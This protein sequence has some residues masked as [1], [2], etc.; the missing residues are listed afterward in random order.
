MPAATEYGTSEVAIANDDEVGGIPLNNDVTLDDDVPCDSSAELPP[1]QKQ[2]VAFYQQ[3][4]HD[5]HVIRGRCWGDV[6]NQV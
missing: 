3:D 6:E 5:S 2:Q 1:Q 4:E